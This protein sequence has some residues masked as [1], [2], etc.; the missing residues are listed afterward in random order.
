MS[1]VRRPSSATTPK[2]S[3]ETRAFL[4]LIFLD[5]SISCWAHK[6]SENGQNCLL[7]FPK[8][9]DDVF[10]CRVLSTNIYIFSL[11]SKGSKETENV[12]IEEAETSKQIINN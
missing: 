11:L 4:T 7:V 6:M 8:N 5:E 2:A 12:P 10:K 3:G 1:S 9:K